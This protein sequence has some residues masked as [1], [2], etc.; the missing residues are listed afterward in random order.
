VNYSALRVAV[1]DYPAW[2]DRLASHVAKMAHGSGNR[3]SAAD[4]AESL[5]TGHMTA[6]LA[7][8]GSLIRCV[9]VTELVDYPR[10][11][12]LRCVGLVGSQPLGWVKLL[13]WLEKEALSMGCARI[14]A[15]H[16]V[17]YERLFV[18]K[19]WSVFHVL[20]EKRL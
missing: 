2:S 18:T 4:I 19:G 16:P 7:L 1:A 20:S 8:D 10:F 12:A 15:L 6:W 9:L 5:T 14:E 3:W 13:D 17:G 11:R